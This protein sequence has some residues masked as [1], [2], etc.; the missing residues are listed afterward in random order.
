MIVNGGDEPCFIEAAFD[1][2]FQFIR[3]RRSVIHPPTADLSVR[4]DFT[5]E[6]DRG[7]ILSLLDE[8]LGVDQVNQGIGTGTDQ[9]GPH[10]RQRFCKS[11]CR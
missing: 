11:C 3:A 6:Q 2:F 9:R 7:M 4:L 5:V 8:A 10:L 1:L